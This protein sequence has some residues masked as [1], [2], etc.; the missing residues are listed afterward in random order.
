V[1]WHQIEKARWGLSF[2]QASTGKPGGLAFRHV[3]GSMREVKGKAGID[4]QPQSIDGILGKFLDVLYQPS[5][6]GLK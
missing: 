1:I 2:V 5:L 4:N 3:L 6:M